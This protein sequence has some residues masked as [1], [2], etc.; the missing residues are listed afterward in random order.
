MRE[1]QVRAVAGDN[2]FGLR[3]P[4][5]YWRGRCSS[6][7]VASWPRIQVVGLSKVFPYALDAAMTV[8][9]QPAVPS[10]SPPCEVCA[11]SLR[12]FGPRRAPRRARDVGVL[13]EPLPPPLATG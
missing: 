2:D 10:P 8:S 5:A 1:T 4:M 3:K 6:D 11:V 9:Q 7:R 12:I 13:A